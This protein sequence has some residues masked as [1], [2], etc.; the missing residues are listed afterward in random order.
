[1]KET[2]IEILKK[3][4][5]KIT[6]PEELKHLYSGDSEI[7]K[8]NTEQDPSISFLE[9]VYRS[10]TI[11]IPSGRLVLTT[12]GE[13]E[14][15]SE[16]IWN[17]P[18]GTHK[19]E[20]GKMGNYDI[21]FIKFREQ[22]ED[23]YELPVFFSVIHPEEKTKNYKLMIQGT[24]SQL[25]IVDKEIWNNEKSYIYSRDPEDLKLFQSKY[26][27]LSPG[28]LL[29]TNIPSAYSD[30]IAD[31]DKTKHEYK[32]FIGFNRNGEILYLQVQRKS[33]Y[34]NTKRLLT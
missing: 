11:Y 7:N 30:I 4:K 33:D 14:Y 8:S 27:Y 9:D 3:W 31:D 13:F 12:E 29:I 2:E 28:A 34:H 22:F 5:E 24:G 25:L 15:A 1:M 26:K 10:E 17:L 18:K 20:F 16:L 19:I 23:V 32:A 21:A 6:F